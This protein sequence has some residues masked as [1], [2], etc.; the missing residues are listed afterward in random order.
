MN[1]PRSDNPTIVSALRIL[2]SDIISQDGIVPCCLLEAADRIE[3]LARNNAE[4]R[5]L[6]QQIR[7]PG[8][9]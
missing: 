9:N 8:R 3:E 2:S 1:V 5:D 7:K 4:L 6:N